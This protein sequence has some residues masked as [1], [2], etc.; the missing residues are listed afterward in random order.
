VVA[1]SPAEKSA[2][3]RKGASGSTPRAIWKATWRSAGR[4]RGDA[5]QV[6]L[7]NKQIQRLTTT[8]GNWSPS[9]CPRGDSDLAWKI[10]RQHASARVPTGQ[11]G[12]YAEW[13]FAHR[14]DAGLLRP[15]ETAIF[16][17]EQRK[18]R[19][20]SITPGPSTTTLRS[21]FRKA[22]DSRRP[23]LRECRQSRRRPRA[24]YKLG[25]TKRGC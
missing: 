18:Y 4:P 10:S 9:G 25:T 13:P 17:A 20:S 15:W 3:T 16:S 12:G 5:S 8:T 11:G 23:A 1:V 21:N 7:N 24:R 22:T 14:A 19:S 2:V 6:Q